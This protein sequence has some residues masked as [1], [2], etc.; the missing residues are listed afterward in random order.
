MT[1]NIDQTVW[2]RR[3]ESV[4]NPQREAKGDLE[5]KVEGEGNLRRIT[6]AEVRDTTILGD[7]LVRGFLEHYHRECAMGFLELQHQYRSWGR[8]KANSIYLAQMFG[9][10][11]ANE[12]ATKAYTRICKEIGPSDLR[13]IEHV[14]HEEAH[15]ELIQ[16]INVCMGVFERLVRV[17]DEVWQQLQK[18]RE[19]REKALETV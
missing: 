19:A 13:I 9:G 10:S 5:G 12:D 2:L 3:G 8:C 7:L 16:V 1:E 18:E 14:C 17:S 11:G 6:Y 4:V 15:S